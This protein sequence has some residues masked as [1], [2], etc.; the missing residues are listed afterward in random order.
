MNEIRFP[1]WLAAV[2]VAGGV[3]IALGLSYIVLTQGGDLSGG[4]KVALVILALVFGTGTAMISAVLGIAVPARLVSP[5]LDLNA[6]CR[7]EHDEA[8]EIEGEPVP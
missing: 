7:P 3:A 2:G 5:G 4:A 6:C 8:A 1:R